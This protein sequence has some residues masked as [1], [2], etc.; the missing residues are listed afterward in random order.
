ML[1]RDPSRAGRRRR[2]A[3]GPAPTWT[4]TRRAM[5]SATNALAASGLSTAASAARSL[6]GATEATRDSAGPAA[7]RQYLG[8][9]LD[10][11][12]SGSEQDDPAPATA[13][14]AGK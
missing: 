8:V 2:A 14:T 11:D 1:E 7:I 9:R 4:A 10:D 5:W 3:G 12:P 6:T 13:A